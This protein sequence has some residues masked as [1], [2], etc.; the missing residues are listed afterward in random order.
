[1]NIYDYGMAPAPPP[2]PTP[3]PVRT[4][5]PAP[6]L[7]L[8]PA[9]TAAASFVATASAPSPAGAASTQLVV[10]PPAAALK[11]LL[12][13]PAAAAS[14]PASTRTGIGAFQV[15]QSKSNESVAERALVSRKDTQQVMRN[16]KRDQKINKIRNGFSPPQQMQ[17]SLQAASK[18]VVHEG[19]TVV[20]A[21][22]NPVTE[23]RLQEKI[24]QYAKDHNITLQEAVEKLN[25]TT[26]VHA[27]AKS[28][29]GLL[30]DRSEAWRAAEL[31]IDFA[32]DAEGKV[33]GDGWGDDN[34]I[35]DD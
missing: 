18:V 14:T 31:E 23:A 33:V 30:Q 11:E 4:T 5:A 29:I 9:S 24:E 22:G 7:S 26:N 17:S 10:A 27:F 2:A 3:P 20:D 25:S 13:A 12:V 1:M 8:A 6:V 21:Q 16:N 35:F 28:F 32:D 15:K 19:K 34:D